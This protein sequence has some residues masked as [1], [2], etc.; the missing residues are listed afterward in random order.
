MVPQSNNIALCLAA[1]LVATSSVQAQ[2]ST[3]PKRQRVFN[4][5]KLESSDAVF[6]IDQQQRRKK[7]N[8][9]SNDEMSISLIT[10]EMPMPP[11]RFEASMPL[12]ESMFG[13]SIPMV[14]LPA[15]EETDTVSLGNDDSADI[16][17]LFSFLAGISA[18]VVGAVALFAKMRRVHRSEVDDEA[19]QSDMENERQPPYSP[20]SGGIEVVPFSDEDDLTDFANVDLTGK[21]HEIILS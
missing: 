12:T 11:Q 6:G 13:L 20:S 1:M 17:I 15:A 21:G 10:P 7:A 19:A 9:R 14:E 2:R 4:N 16:V 5:R 8:L 3:V 18:M